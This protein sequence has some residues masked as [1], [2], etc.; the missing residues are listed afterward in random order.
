[1]VQAKLKKFTC[2]LSDETM[3]KLEE[4]MEKRYPRLKDKTTT[5]TWLIEDA[6]EIANREL[7]K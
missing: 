6:W 1:M 2:R 4:V 5:I 7:V 3:R